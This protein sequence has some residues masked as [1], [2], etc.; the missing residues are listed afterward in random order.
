VTKIMTTIA[1]YGYGYGRTNLRTLKRSR[2]PFSSTVNR[3]CRGEA[4]GAIGNTVR[5]PCP[6]LPLCDPQKPTGAYLAVAFLKS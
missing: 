6:S 5:A 2:K 1:R 3:V 4:C